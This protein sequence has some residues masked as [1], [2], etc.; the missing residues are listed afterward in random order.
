LRRVS[1]EESGNVVLIPNWTQ[2]VTEYSDQFQGMTIGNLPKSLAKVPDIAAHMR[3]PKGMLLTPE[4]RIPRARGLMATA[5]ALAL[6]NNGWKLHSRP[7]EFY[8]EKNGQQLQPYQLT[9]Q[10][11][12]GVFQ[13]E[14]WT[15]MCSRHGI[16][17]IEL[18]PPQIADAT[19]S[20]SSPS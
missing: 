14:A 8:L 7:G 15:E 9:T 20:T 12:D 1:W 2:A 4:Q 10:C 3:D 16:E 5:F 6:V 13:H 18:K 17:N 11:S 19:A